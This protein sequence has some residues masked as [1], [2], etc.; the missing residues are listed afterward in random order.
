MRG[1]LKYESD[2]PYE[3]LT[4][5]VSPWSY[6]THENQYVNV[7]ET[8]RKAISINPYLKVFVANGYYDLATP[9]YATRYTVNHLGLD[10]SL[11]ANISLGFYE[12]GH[13]M[14]I[15]LPSLARLRS[16]LADFVASA[17]PPHF[18][19][20]IMPCRASARAAAPG[21]IRA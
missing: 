15:H 10:P 17:L 19:F 21:H 14:Y 20:P 1:E 16:D 18:H 4:E 12:A 5:R 3:I 9:Y 11:S 13:M 8:L 6:A 7:A 2:L